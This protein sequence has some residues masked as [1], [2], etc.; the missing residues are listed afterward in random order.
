MRTIIVWSAIIAL[1]AAA[2]GATNTGVSASEQPIGSTGPKPT[3][4]TYGLC[5]GPQNA[6]AFPS[7]P[8]PVVDGACELSQTFEATSPGPTS[9]S[10]CG[11]FTVAFGP[12]GDLK[13]NWK[14]ISLS[15]KWADAPL[16]AATCTSAYLAFAGWGYR[17]DNA[18]CTVGAWERIG[19]AQ[20]RKGTWNTTSQVCYL[21][22]GANTGPKDYKTLNIDVI[23]TQGQGASAVRKRAS[24][25]IYAQRGNGRCFS[26]TTT[27]P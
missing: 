12:M 21:A 5:S 18:A 11:G 26:M 23:A 8:V 13:S 4:A 27:R 2:I 3:V 6:D 20:G 14:T 1:H 17:C 7:S 19:V 9:G 15:A 22:L 10:S 16:T 24:A 25:K